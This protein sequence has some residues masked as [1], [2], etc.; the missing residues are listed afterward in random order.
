MSEASLDQGA[1]VLFYYAVEIKDM[2]SIDFKQ[3]TNV[4]DIDK[5]DEIRYWNH[6]VINKIEEGNL[7]SKT[8]KQIGIK[9]I[10][11]LPKTYR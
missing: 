8:N 3:Q 4:I 1:L 7:I 2:K 6:S 9:V 10:D 5:D 11:E